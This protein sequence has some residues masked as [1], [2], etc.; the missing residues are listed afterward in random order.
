MKCIA[1]LLLALA[2]TASGLAQV[3]TN[4]S[5]TG[6]PSAA[7]N[8]ITATTGSGNTVVLQTSP[9]ITSPTL[10]TPNIGAATGTTLGIS[11]AFTSTAGGTWFV[12]S[13][14]T[15]GQTNMQFANTGGSFQAGVEPSGAAVLFTGSGGAY[16]TVL[17]SY[18]NTPLALGT[19]GATRIFVAAAG[20][21]TIPSLTTAAGTPN[22]ICQ[23]D[24][25][26]E[27]TVNAALTCT[28]SSAR[29]KDAIAPFKGNGLQLVAAMKPD[30]FYYKDRLDR[31]RIGLMAEDLAAIDPRLSEWD[32]NGRP[33]SIDFPAIMAVMVKA[34]QE[35]QAQIRALTIKV[36]GNATR[37]QARLQ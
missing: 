13:G 26:K 29:F 20:G 17:G 8:G 22:S 37:E 1:A 11:G 10:T 31:A 28:V 25:T 23:N 5:L 30:T 33:N 6:V 7:L 24:A 32:Q 16:A 12:G 2:W 19:N 3:T 14:A 21:V 15:S 34:I 36:R 27:I 18:T 35:Q 4:P 9:T